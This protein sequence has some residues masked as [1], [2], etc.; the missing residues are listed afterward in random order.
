[1]T[2]INIKLYKIH[3][4]IYSFEENYRFS[5]LIPFSFNHAKYKFNKFFMN[6]VLTKI[7]E[8]LDNLTLNIT[9]T[10]KFKKKPN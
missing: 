10:I 2:I 1:M 7:Y 3:N 8:F 5:T 6:D 9:L 4:F